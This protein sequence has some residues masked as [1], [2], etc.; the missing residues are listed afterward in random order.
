MSDAHKLC[1]RHDT[2][3]AVQQLVE[4]YPFVPYKSRPKQVVT[5]NTSSRS[6]S[7][8]TY[9]TESGVAKG[10]EARSQEAY[11]REHGC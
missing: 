5:T 1:K 7:D 8:V 3:A 11:C 6:L 9:R 2:A 10:G 4:V